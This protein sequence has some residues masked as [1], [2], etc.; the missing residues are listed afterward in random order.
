MPFQPIFIEDE[1]R[2]GT[3]MTRD[4]VDIREPSI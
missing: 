4:E 1:P 2:G 3:D